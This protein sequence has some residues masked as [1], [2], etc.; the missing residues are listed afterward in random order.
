ML[1]DAK[2]DVFCD[3]LLIDPVGIS[4]DCIMQGVDGSVF[5]ASGGVLFR[6][7][8]GEEKYSEICR[9]DEGKHPY[10]IFM[11]FDKAQ[12]IYYVPRGQGE[13]KISRDYGKNFETCLRVPGRGHFRGFAVDNHGAVFLGSYAIGSSAAKGGPAQLF[14]TED[15]GRNWEP[16]LEIRCRHFH[17]V[18]FNPYNNFLYA[19]AGEYEKE[20][21]YTDAYSIFRSKDG[22]RSWHV[23]VEPQKRDER[24]WGR[25]LYLG[26]GFLKNRVILTTDHAEGGNG[27]DVFDDFGEN[28]LHVPERVY[29]NPPETHSEKNVP[30]LCWRVVNW[31]SQLYIFCANPHGNSILLRSHD[32][33]NWEKCAVFGK[34]VGRQPEFSPWSDRLYVSGPGTGWC[35][36]PRT[37][38]ASHL[39]A[40]SL[41]PEF[42]ADSLAEYDKRM[43]TFFCGGYYLRSLK[44]PLRFMKILE[45]LKEEGL[46]KNA[47]I[48]D[49]GCGV[50]SL[51]LSGTAFGY[52]RIVGVEANPRWLAG[53]RH[54]YE[55]AWPCHAPELCIVPRGE[56]TLPDM[57]RPW[58]AVVI[59]GV[60]TGNGNNVPFG[61]AIV[62]SYNGLGDG[63]LICFNVDPATYGETSPHIFIHTLAKNG[64]TS[65]RCRKFVNENFLITA[66][67]S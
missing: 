49:C 11:A 5:C 41:T 56:F 42:W 30:G 18:A 53:L 50:G 7:S 36:R 57:G 13:V 62:A 38:S 40:S 33:V 59:L 22:G 4:A 6:R 24:G 55:K 31:N 64:F 3:D 28:R 29:D 1:E 34:D 17:D 52:G 14:M 15:E 8:P 39:P 43:E 26:I 63:G 65:I 45:L 32:G 16:V 66:R 37:C 12:N 44:N 61:E 46:G 60:F 51:L 48:V 58:D 10:A 20:K 2:V 25:P 47:L 21:Y 27:I 35:I 54:L 9:P 67:R 23:V 19:I